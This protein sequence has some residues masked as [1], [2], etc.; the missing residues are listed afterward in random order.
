MAKKKDLNAIMKRRMEEALQDLEQSR[1]R[2][3]NDVD[4]KV[5][6]DIGTDAEGKT[7][8]DP[9]IVNLPNDVKNVG[10]EVF[11]AP[12]INPSR[13]RAYTIAYNPTTNTLI[14]IFRHDVWWQYN[15]VPVSMWEAL[16]SSP[17]TGKYLK[18]SGLDNWGD[19]G[20]A[21]IDALSEST[22]ARLSYTAGMASRIQNGQLPTWDD[23]FL[24]PKE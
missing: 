15:N 18:A 3:L 2:N 14:V 19:M 12:T 11:N 5:A 8:T 6:W 1:E 13:P 4:R 16:K 22:K 20:P 21:N 9:W 7:Q 10:V 17:S 23:M 24:P